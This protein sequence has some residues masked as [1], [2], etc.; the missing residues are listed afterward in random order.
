M[1]L[2]YPTR[3]MW[4]HRAAVSCF[5]VVLPYGHVCLNVD[6]CQH[7]D[8]LFVVMCLSA[9]EVCWYQ[10]LAVL[11]FMWVIVCRVF[12]L[13]IGRHVLYSSCA[14]LCS[15]LSCC[16]G[17][18]GVSMALI[19][20][21]CWKF[22]ASSSTESSCSCHVSSSKFFSPVHCQIHCLS[23][24][25]AANYLGF[26]LAVQTILFLLLEVAGNVPDLERLSHGFSL[27][28]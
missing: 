11:L 24:K 6:C 16:V 2:I 20:P 28:V 5:V 25:V 21:V 18:F 23:R 22:S 1:A 9:C 27:R 26:P 4:N 10:L 12:F 19:F 13:H 3:A 7:R 14:R 8:D 17:C 15:I